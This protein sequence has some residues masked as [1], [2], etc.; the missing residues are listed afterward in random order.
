MLAR[1]GSPCRT[2]T[3]FLPLPD[4]EQPRDQGR[5]H[6]DRR[7]PADPL[8]RSKTKILADAAEPPIWGF[9]GSST[10]Q[11]EGQASDCVLQPV[12]TC[13]TRSAAATNVLVLC[14]V[15]NTDFTPH[16]SNTRAAIVEV[17]EHFA[18]QEP[19]FGIEQEYTLFDGSRPLGF[20][21]RGGFPGPQGPYYCG[22]GATTSSA[23]RS[24]RP[25]STPA[26]RPA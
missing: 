11:A 1:G 18:G 12:L 20:P 6:L 26:W 4:E 21:E 17:A 10:N 13:R 24:S 25:T 2:A 19:L 16:E 14:E 22:V 5:V 23:A 9:D 7:H 15:Q 8:L 3:P